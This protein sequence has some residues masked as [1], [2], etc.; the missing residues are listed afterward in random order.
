MANDDRS[1]QPNS[2]G[3]ESTGD[4]FTTTWPKVWQVTVSIV[5]LILLLWYLVLQ[6][7]ESEFL[8]APRTANLR[9]LQISI[10][11]PKSEKEETP[12]EGE[13]E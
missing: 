10:G 5:G 6:K 8:I 3:R 1:P 11:P 2:G 4:W 9:G 13:A 12:V 7:G